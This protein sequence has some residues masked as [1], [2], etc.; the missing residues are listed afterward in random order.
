MHVHAPILEAHCKSRVVQGFIFTRPTHITHSLADRRSVNLTSVMSV[1]VSFLAFIAFVAF[2]ALLAF[3]A[4]LVL[5]AAAFGVA[6]AMV[7]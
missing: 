7:C 2:L 1:S 4:F 6:L 5:P 3:V